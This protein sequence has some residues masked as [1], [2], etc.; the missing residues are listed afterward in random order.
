M[1][2]SL[3]Y[4][5]PAKSSARELLVQL[6]PLSVLAGVVGDIIPGSRVSPSAPVDLLRRHPSSSSINS[7]SCICGGDAEGGQ[8]NESGPEICGGRGTSSPETD[9]FTTFVRAPVP[10]HLLADVAAER[11]LAGELEDLAGEA[12]ES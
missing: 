9:L 7:S 1:R 4:N 3:W 11:R 2:R 8:G 12:Q 6:R 5:V 10:T